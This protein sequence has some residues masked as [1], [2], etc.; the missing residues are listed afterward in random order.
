MSTNLASHT[1][2]SD[3]PSL[4][5]DYTLLTT[6]PTPQTYM[7]LRSVTGMSPRSHAGALVGLPNSLHA[8]QIQHIPSA[9]IVGMGRIIGDNGLFYQIVDIGVE[10]AH[11][12]QGLAKAIMGELM[13]WIE[14]TGKDGGY[15]SLIADGEAKRLYK[16]FGFEET[17]PASVGMYYRVRK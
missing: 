6:V 2:P 10:P 12:G 13:R 11:Q 4:P 17:A 5:A 1:L 7:H 8:A 15:V 9:A 3:L 14:A 16:I